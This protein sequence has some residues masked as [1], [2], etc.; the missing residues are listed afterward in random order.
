MIAIAVLPAMVITS[1][2]AEEEIPPMAITST[3]AEEEIPP[4]DTDASCITSSC[5]AGMGK[6]KYVH[7]VGVNPKHCVKCHGVVSKTEHKFRLPEKSVELCVQCHSGQYIM[8]PDIKGDAPEIMDV[9]L[10]EEG[11]FTYFHSPFSKGKCTECHDPHESDYYMHLKGNYPRGFYARFSPDQ[12]G[13]CLKCHNKFLK[14]LINPRTF[15]DTQFR[16]GNLNLHFRHVNKTKGR[17]CRACHHHH[18]S[19]QP[20]L[21]KENFIFGLRKLEVNYKKTSTGGGC[22]PSCHAPV[23]YDRY[24]PIDIYMRTT[25]RPGKDAL[26]SELRSSRTRDLERLKEINKKKETEK[27]KE[28]MQESKGK[29]IE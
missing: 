12:Y 4:I 8:P 28:K 24:N 18:G 26:P 5:H 3:Y 29:D 1:T 15:S 27:A 21:L 23:K 22:R 14:A 13:L 9:D 7:G 6:K 17:T 25:P 19:E 11:E 10:F 16:N 2:Y 20:K